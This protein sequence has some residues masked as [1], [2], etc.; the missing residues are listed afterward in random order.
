LSR[1]KLSFGEPEKLKQRHGVAFYR[2]NLLRSLDPEKKG[3]EAIE[4]SE[5]RKRE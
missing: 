5:E 3:T 4:V 2:N 1:F